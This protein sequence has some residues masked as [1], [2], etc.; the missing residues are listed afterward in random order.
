[1]K[2]LSSMNTKRWQIQKYKKEN[3]K[4]WQI[5]NGVRNHR[6]TSRC[7]TGTAIP[8][9]LSSVKKTLWSRTCQ[10]SPLVILGTENQ[11]SWV[12]QP[13][14][15]VLRSNKNLGCQR[16]LFWHIVCELTFSGTPERSQS[17]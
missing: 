3:T 2:S 9:Q 1:M 15:A 4:K 16:D 5:Q 12:A 14:K 8:V 13:E 11:S 7:C 17:G 6:S 10:A